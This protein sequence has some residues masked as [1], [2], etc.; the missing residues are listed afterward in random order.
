MMR[1]LK[2]SLWF[3]IPFG[4]MTLGCSSGLQHLLAGLAIDE[5]LDSAQPQPD[6]GMDGSAGHDGLNCWDLNGDGL[7]DAEEDTDGDGQATVYDC[8]GGD[9]NDG[10]TGL[11]GPVGE[12]GR[13]GV[14]G[15]RGPQGIPGPIGPAGADGAP[16]TDDVDDDGPPFGGGPDGVHRND[17]R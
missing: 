12:P 14:Q 3:W 15:V 1:H 10:E 13:P 17:D 2:L 16:G 5:A 8:R 9:G 4:L 7:F 6:D 11:Q